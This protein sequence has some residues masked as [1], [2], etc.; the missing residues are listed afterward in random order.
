MMHDIS[1]QI[2]VITGSARGIGLAIAERFASAKATVIV[3]D[4]NSE[5]VDKAVES[6]KDQGGKA[7]G[8]IGNVTDAKGIEELFARIVA[9][10]GAIDTLI[11]NAGVTRDNLVLRMKEEEWQLVMDINLKGSFICTQKA[12]KHMMKARQ[13]SIINIASVIGLMGNAGQANY[14]ASKGG[15]IAFTKSC[16]KEF[17]SRNVRVNAVAPGFIETEMTATLSEEIRA[18]YGKAI[19]LGKMGSPADVAKVCMFLASEYSSYITGQTIAV[20]GGLTMH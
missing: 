9:E 11:N 20:D 5:L 13:G 6:L 4:L 19:P 14:A 12:F 17:A 8:Y 7:F 3:I 16:A 1:K 10:H 2:V 18:S 15:M